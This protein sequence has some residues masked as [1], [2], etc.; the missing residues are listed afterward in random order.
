LTATAFPKSGRSK[1][2]GAPSFLADAPSARR[3][4]LFDA[5]F[6]LVF[7]LSTRSGSCETAN[8]AV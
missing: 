7:L 3:F 6:V 1:R 2:V 5:P 4:S 8:S